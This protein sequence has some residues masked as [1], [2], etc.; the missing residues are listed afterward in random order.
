MADFAGTAPPNRRHKEK[1]ENYY[2]QAPAFAAELVANY[3]LEWIKVS[4]LK[5]T[6][7]LVS[8]PEDLPWQSR[9]SIPRISEMM[10]ADP[11]SR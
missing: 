9:P 11:F 3:Y 1:A 5:K 4:F 7:F 6:R 10:L 8:T 2:L